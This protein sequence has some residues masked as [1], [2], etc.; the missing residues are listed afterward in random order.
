MDSEFLNTIV[1]T[2]QLAAIS[3]FFL[4]ILSIPIS[5]FL[6]FVQSKIK[7]I[8]ETIVSLPIVLPPTVLGFYFLVLFNP[9]SFFGQWLE[10]KVGIRLT[11][12]FIG[13]VI[14]SIFYSLPFMVQSLNTGFHR[15]PISII[16]ASYILGKSRFMTLV[17]VILPN[18][19]SA[20][21]SGILVCFAHILGEFGIILM[22]GGNI[23][24][25]TKVASIAIFEEL[26]ALN[27]EKANQYAM[28]L[29]LCSFLCLLIMQFIP[30][31]RNDRSIY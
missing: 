17:H 18:M 24:G 22:I 31:E 11:F 8:F 1:L 2:F 16:E 15:V 7:F 27:Y 12:S 19:K 23:P 28:I 29:I 4:L 14:G 6:I 21:L 3:T 26:Q 30:K 10:S 9:D 25:E 5:Y 13:L 20:I